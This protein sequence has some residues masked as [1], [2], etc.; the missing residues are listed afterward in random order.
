M[1]A[2]RARRA[3]LAAACAAAAALG[4]CH[5]QWYQEG[6]RTE[7]V[8][9]DVVVRTEPAGA[10]V[11]FNGKR[12]DRAPVRIPVEYDHTIEQ[13]VRQ[14]NAS[15][16]WSPTAILTH[17]KEEMKRH[18]YEGNRHKVTASMDGYDD[19]TSDLLLEGEAE[20]DVVLKLSRSAAR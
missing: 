7:I 11:Y 10:T 5:S 2:V 6:S 15:P 12:M 19:A 17:A 8:R 20:V 3:A 4:G 13:W 1:S 16:S 18:V 14:S 9:T